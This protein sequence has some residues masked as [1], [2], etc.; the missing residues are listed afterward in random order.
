MNATV[1]IW[2]SEDNFR[3]LILSFH[4]WDLRMELGSSSLGGKYFY[5][6]SHLSAPGWSPGFSC[7]W[8]FS[9]SS[10][11]ATELFLRFPFRLFITRM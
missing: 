2:R 11:H 7:L 4:Q 9:V 6:L 3:E 8:F 5:L 10:W 1:C